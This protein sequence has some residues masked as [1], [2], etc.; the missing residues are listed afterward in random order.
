MAL[1]G[2]HDHEG[3]E[4]ELRVESL[5][6]QGNLQ[7]EITLFHRLDRC[8]PGHVVSDDMTDERGAHG[9]RH[10]GKENTKERFHQ[11]SHAERLTDPFQLI[12]GHLAGTGQLETVPQRNEGDIAQSD[13]DNDTDEKHVPGG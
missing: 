3:K 9:H 5:E 4:Y 10:A 13:K 6:N 2:T 11:P 1:K 8:R 12:G 7:K